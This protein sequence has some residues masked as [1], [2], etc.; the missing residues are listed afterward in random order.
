MPA[1]ANFPGKTIA[2]TSN[3][4]VSVTDLLPTFLSL[5][6][7]E[8]PGD[9][10]KGRPVY[11]I[12]GRS[13]LPLLTSAEADIHDGAK[14]IG[15]EILGRSALRKGEWKLL[16]TPKPHGTD[17]WKLFNIVKD[18]GELDNKA[19]DMP[20]VMDD[21]LKEWQRYEQENN[22]VYAESSPL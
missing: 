18:P 15:H 10:Y 20:D 12:Q 2:G 4:L 5:A 22:L 14:V 7:I 1:I 17:Q 9:S 3:A 13:L 16:R 21:L 11:P 19:A 8:H 6:A